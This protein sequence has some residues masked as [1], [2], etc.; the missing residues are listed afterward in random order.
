MG[1]QLQLATGASGG[2]P[3]PSAAHHLLASIHDA[4]QQ[5]HRQGIEFP[6]IDILAIWDDTLERLRSAGQLAAVPTQVDLASLAVEYEV[7]VN[8][9][10]PMPRAAES[11]RDL[12]ERGLRLGII[13]NAQFFTRELFPA[14]LHQTAEALGF[15]PALQFYSYQ[16]GR[17]KPGSFLYKQ[18]AEALFDVGVPA[19]NVLYIGN[20]MLNDVTAAHKVGF[21]TALFAGDARSL[22]LRSNDARVAGIVPDV[23]VTDLA[24]LAGCI[25]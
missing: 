24:Q 16:T 15:E 4:H 8:P 2:D 12:R 7:R 1:V 25:E 9:T 23:I 21:Q 13:S 20:D 18:A 6:E 17:A 14:L 10:W 3:P 11:L 22:R 5:A 19:R